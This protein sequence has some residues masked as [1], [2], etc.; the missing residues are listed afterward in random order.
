MGIVPADATW[1][2]LVLTRCMQLLCT[3]CAW[4]VLQTALEDLDAAINPIH[5]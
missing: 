4:A 5:I 2:P 1:H 3:L